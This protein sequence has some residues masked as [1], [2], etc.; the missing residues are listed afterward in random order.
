MSSPTTPAHLKRQIVSSP[1]PPTAR[2]TVTYDD[3][4]AGA[5]DALLAVLSQPQASVEPR[6]DDE[7]PAETA[8]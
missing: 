5:A 1:N 4:P 8:A 7:A 2:I 3:D 6:N